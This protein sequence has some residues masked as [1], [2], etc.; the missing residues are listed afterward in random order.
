MQ[1]RLS[2]I[3]ASKLSSQLS[4]IKKSLG[5]TLIKF[6]DASIDF[7]K[8]TDKHHFETLEV[9]FRAIK[10][11]YKQVS[12][13]NMFSTFVWKIIYTSVRSLVMNIY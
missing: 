12:T 9:Y 3:T 2:V 8:F 11:H 10:A 7:E 4:E 6:E 13:F 1:I 5:I